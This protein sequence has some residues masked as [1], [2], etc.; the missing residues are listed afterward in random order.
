VILDGVETLT[1]EQQ[2]T[3]LRWLD[4]C[5][6]AETQVVT[7]TA[8]ALYTEV[9]AGRFLDGLYYRL[10]MITVEVGAAGVRW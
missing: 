5:L 7:V 9:Q 10:N 1:V 6:R 8:A 2:G 3:L 4:E